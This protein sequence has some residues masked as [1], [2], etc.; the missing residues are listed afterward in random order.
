MDALRRI[1]RLLSVPEQRSAL[2]AFEGLIADLHNSSGDLQAPLLLFLHGPSGCGKTRLV[3]WLVE[4]VAEQASTLSAAI[5][6]SESLFSRLDCGSV[7]RVTC[8]DEPDL[9]V[10]EDAQF[11]PLKMVEMFLQRLDE[12][13]A[14]DRPTVVTAVASPRHLKFRGDPFPARLTSRFAAGLVIS[15]PLPQASSRRLVLEEHL[16]A[17]SLSATEDVVDFLVN[18]SRGFRSIEGAIHQLKLLDRLEP[19]SMQANMLLDHFQKQTES[20][21]SSLERIV[22]SVA[23]HFQVATKDIRSHS[24]RRSFVVPRHVSMYLARRLTPLSFQQIGA[25]FGGCDHATVLHAC[26]KMEGTLERDP[27]LSGAIRQLHDYLA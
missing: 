5:V 21:K 23:G 1:D 10:V 7:D 22:Q 14:N 12:R 8:Q 3:Q 4:Q 13:Q 15:V 20:E 6:S 27:Q 16:R 24:R 2:A 25:Y 18:H 9:L 17:S 11:L 26:R 19:G